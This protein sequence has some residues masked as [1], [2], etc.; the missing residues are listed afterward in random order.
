MFDNIQF[1]DDDKNKKEID[2]IILKDGQEIK[3]NDVTHVIILKESSSVDGAYYVM[4][5]KII[6]KIDCEGIS[7]QCYMIALVTKFMR[8]HNVSFDTA[9][10]HYLEFMKNNKKNKG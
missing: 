2:K 9:L 1:F 4:S 3:V 8:Y 6:D 10:K 7:N 5:E